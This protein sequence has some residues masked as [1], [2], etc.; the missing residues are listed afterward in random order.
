M[1]FSPELFSAALSNLYS[2]Q[3]VDYEVMKQSESYVMSVRDQPEG[4][5]LFLQL[6]LNLNNEEQDSIRKG[7]I[8]NLLSIVNKKWNQLEPQVQ[9]KARELIL[10]VIQ[11]QLTFN[12]LS[13]MADICADIFRYMGFWNEIIRLICVSFQESDLQLTMLFLKKI[14]PVMHEQIVVQMNP[15]FKNM[16][17][18]GL[19]SQDL[20]TRLNSVRL[21]I[22]IGEKTKDS[23]S[24]L[25]AIQYLI[26][27]LSKSPQY[28]IDNQNTKLFSELWQFVSKI[29]AIKNDDGSIITEFWQAANPIIS[30]NSLNADQRRLVL[31]QFEPVIS[32]MPIEM[33]IGMLSILIILAIQYVT[34]EMELLPEDYLTF[35]DVSLAKR[36]K[37]V[38]QF[39]KGKIIEL[40]SKYQS[41][42]P[43][44]PS[45]IVSLSLLLSMMRNSP[46]QM[47][48]EIDLVKNS[49]NL[50]FQTNNELV[51]CTALLI[52][53]ILNEHFYESE[54]TDHS[55]SLMQ[56]VM[57]LLISQSDQIRRFA[58]NAFLTLCEMC[59]S[60]VEGLFNH[61]WSFKTQNLIKKDSYDDYLSILSKVISLSNDVS[62]DI[63]NEVLKFV[64]EILF[65]TDESFIPEKSVSLSVLSSLFTKNSSLLPGL[66]P[67]IVPI[68][69]TLLT[70]NEDPR[71]IGQAL[72]FLT[73]LAKSYRSDVLEFVRNYFPLLTNMISGNS[74]D[75]EK[76]H[77]TAMNTASSIIKFCNDTTLVQP[78]IDE[79]MQLF[80]FSDMNTMI[81]VCINISYMSKGFLAVKSEAVQPIYEALIGIVKEK[82]DDDLLTSCFEA[83]SK[84][85]KRCRPLNP[86]FFDQNTH[87]LIDLIL[88]G[89][90]KYLNDDP[91][92]LFDL[93]YEMSSYLLSFIDVYL[94]VNP[95]DAN[96]VYSI[97]FKWMSKAD[98][99]VVANIIG[100]VTE[101]LKMTDIDSQILSAIIQYLMSISG[102]I[103][104]VRLRN[105]VAYFLSAFIKKF[106]DQ[107]QIVSQ[108][109]PA[110]DQWWLE[111]KGKTMGYQACLSNI[112][113]LYLRLLEAGAQIPIETV[114]NAI[115]AF[116]PADVTET[117]NMAV[118][119]L[120]IFLT[121]QE[122][123]QL[124]Q[125]IIVN[126]CVSLSELLT[127][128][129]TSKNL[130][131]LTPET[132][133]QIQQL[134]RTIVSGNEN[135]KNQLMQKYQNNSEKQKILSQYF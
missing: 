9:E 22:L 63:Q 73:N 39:V 60:E 26:P 37:E 6:I 131:K 119:I 70:Y 122:N 107:V 78:M 72:I 48:N 134:F 103:A 40:I 20:E 12:E 93:Q 3:N 5:L 76:V 84:L 47:M 81:E 44:Y 133:S 99:E 87:Q 101:P 42:E 97:L 28:L 53:D 123:Q 89:Q 80:K 8:V 16:A 41:P 74:I 77:L 82:E 104:A 2:G 113:V 19:Q 83:L 117:E 17:L 108:F 116:P 15:A 105:N 94:R 92:A 86:N 85:Y 14:Y 88:A 21:H 110:L 59:D 7:A 79:I 66:L 96:K 30:E 62:D 98:E 52:V 61:L 18:I 95:P 135:A 130:K 24:V 126:T 67:N 65:S 112:A 43:D 51:L 45:F 91:E 49:L 55:V 109:I 132:F 11:M 32:K 69:N 58:A 121:M 118:A 1:D 64:E 100:A 29:L 54:M 125:G 127:M 4:I 115:G 31:T 10:Q 102:Q 33:L 111:G 27:E 114:S 106:P 36:T 75:D 56:Q 50:A 46:D 35:L 71:V 124:I 23:S 128:P 129:S 34:Q 38:F 120:N 90:I 13:M 57:P 25:P 68:L